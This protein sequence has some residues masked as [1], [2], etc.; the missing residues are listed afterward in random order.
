MILGYP[1]AVI[2]VPMHYSMKQFDHLQNGVE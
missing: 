2:R 1:D